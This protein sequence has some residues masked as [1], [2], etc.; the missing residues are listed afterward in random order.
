MENFEGWR[1]EVEGS[2]GGGSK[3]E[4][5]TEGTKNQLPT[6]HRCIMSKGSVVGLFFYG[7]VGGFGGLF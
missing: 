5:L 4:G 6:F 2:R 7:Q 1:V 3:V